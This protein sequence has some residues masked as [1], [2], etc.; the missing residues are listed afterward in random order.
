[1]SVS[2]P[3]FSGIKRSKQQKMQLTGFVH[4]EKKSIHLYRNPFIWKLKKNSVILNNPLIKKNYSS[5]KRIKLNLKT[6]DIISVKLDKN[7]WKRVVR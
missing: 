5:K 4:L 1:M 6:S 2:F 3:A 7:R